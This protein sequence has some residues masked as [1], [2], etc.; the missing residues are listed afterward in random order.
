MQCV[1]VRRLQ[2]SPAACEM[3]KLCFLFT[4]HCANDLRGRRRKGNSWHTYAIYYIYK[5]Y[6][7]YIGDSLLRCRN[8][9]LAVGA[10]KSHWCLFGQACGG[11]ATSAAGGALDRRLRQAEITE[12]SIAIR[13]KRQ[14]A[15][16][17]RGCLLLCLT[18]EAYR[19]LQRMNV[20]RQ[21]A[22]DSWTVVRPQ[23]WRVHSISI[24]HSYVTL[25]TLKVQNDEATA[26]REWEWERV[27]LAAPDMAIN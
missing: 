14:Q 25:N 15:E 4:P 18:I 7:L 12:L 10:Y 11:K 26:E 2:L 9:V 13:N 22:I 20:M 1:S 19:D 5:G 3:A 6:I 23:S 21:L 8:N 16:Q 17:A 27:Q 24:N